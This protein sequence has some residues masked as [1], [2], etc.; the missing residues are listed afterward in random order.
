MGKK[1]IIKRLNQALEKKDNDR[2]REIFKI[3]IMENG[4]VIYFAEKTYIT[5]QT[6]YNYLSGRSSMSFE[7]FTRALKE[8]GIRLRIVT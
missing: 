6:I 8:V 2:I 3:I 7:F 5:R 4:G 1:I